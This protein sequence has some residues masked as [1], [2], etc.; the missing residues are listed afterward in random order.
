M[1]QSSLFF[2]FSQPTSTLFIFLSITLDSRYNPSLPSHII[3]DSLFPYDINQDKYWTHW[4]YVCMC[5]Y[6]PKKEKKEGQQNWCR[7][8]NNTDMFKKKTRTK[9]CKKRNYTGKK[10]IIQGHK[11]KKKL[12]LFKKKTRGNQHIRQIVRKKKRQ[13]WY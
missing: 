6:I 5:V 11:T 4:L 9:L 8:W 10:T 1:N 3:N 7:Q 2:L 12:N 13:K